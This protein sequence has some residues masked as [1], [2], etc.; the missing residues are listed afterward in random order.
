MKPKQTTTISAGVPDAACTSLMACWC[1]L[2][3][4]TWRSLLLRSAV[5]FSNFWKKK[6]LISL[7]G[8]SKAQ[9]YQSSIA[10][11]SSA[12]SVSHLPELRVNLLI[13]PLVLLWLV[14]AVVG[15]AKLPAP[16]LIKA[17]VILYI[18]AFAVP[19]YLQFI[20]S[21]LRARY[22]FNPGLGTIVVAQSD[23]V[24]VSHRYSIIWKTPLGAIAAIELGA[25]HWRLTVLQ[26]SHLETESARLFVRSG[27]IKH[28][29][30]G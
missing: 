20:V 18:L 30:A 4:R 2:L 11:L 21:Q 23:G 26:Y 3:A 5:V 13:V 8:C 24:L 29:K 6:T 15:A 16:A 19:R 27:K 14:A 22:Y 28:R 17:I 25:R 9:K 7:A 1:H 12:S 10:S